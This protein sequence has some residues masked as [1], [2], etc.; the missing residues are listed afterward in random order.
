MYSPHPTSEIGWERH[1]DSGDQMIADSADTK[2]T[3]TDTG[4]QCRMMF[5]V[6]FALGE[7]NLLL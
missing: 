1:V 7:N 6:S 4:L 5:L 2:V 3:P